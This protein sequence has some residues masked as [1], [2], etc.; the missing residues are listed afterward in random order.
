MNDLKHETKK[1]LPL[2]NRSLVDFGSSIAAYTKIVFASL[3]KIPITGND[4]SSQRVVGEEKLRQGGRWENKMKS[5][6][7]IFFF[8]AR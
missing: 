3:L 5:E 2:R 7:M 8:L 6:L 4:L 1:T